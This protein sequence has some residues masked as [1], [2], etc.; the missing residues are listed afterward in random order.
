MNRIKL[1]DKSFE[2]SIPET[3]ILEQVR[4]V[5][6]EMN[7]DFAGKAPLFITVLNGAFV[8][9]ADLFR[10]I[11]MPS[12]IRFVRL[13]SYSGMC[14]EGEVKELLGFDIDVKDR[15]VV[16]VEDIVDSGITME[17]LLT[18]LSEKSPKS[19]SIASLL[20]KPANLKV[21]IEVKYKC[22]E[23]PNDFIVG[24]GLDYDDLGRNLRSIYTV[25]E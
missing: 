8:F 9:A 6:R 13:A 16:I 25:I 23:I 14:S 18:M 19:V 17:K 2:L 10:E 24:Y 15:D 4:R 1:K 7:R 21:D 5:G 20:V 3:A 22:F 11:N 12:E